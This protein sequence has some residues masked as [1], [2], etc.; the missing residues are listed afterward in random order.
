MEDLW[1]SGIWGI[2]APAS[3]TGPDH[4]LPTE[5]AAEA[6]V[7]GP[8]SQAAGAEDV[9]T[10]Q[11]AWRFVLLPAQMAHQGVDAGTV[12]HT[13]L[14]QAAEDPSRHLKAQRWGHGKL[15]E[16]LGCLHQTLVQ[17]KVGTQ[18]LKPKYS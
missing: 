12:H 11:Q 2:K 7:I 15:E 14:L 9:V 3:G 5:G 10:V 13:Q 4:L 18:G 16:L 17:R 6:A 8:T 1:I